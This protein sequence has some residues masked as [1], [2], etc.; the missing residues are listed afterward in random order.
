MN[1]Y[2]SSS[3]LLAFEMFYYVGGFFLGYISRKIQEKAEKDEIEQNK[4]EGE[5]KSA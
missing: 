3:E 2:L 1:Y 5:V 4:K